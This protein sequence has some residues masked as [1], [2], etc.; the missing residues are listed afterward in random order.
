MHKNAFAT[1]REFTTLPGFL[2]DLRRSKKSG[3]GKRRKRKEGKKKHQN[4]MEERKRL[5]KGCF[6]PLRGMGALCMSF[7]GL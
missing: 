7:V 4:K 5:V 2:L 1:L 6:L 3:E